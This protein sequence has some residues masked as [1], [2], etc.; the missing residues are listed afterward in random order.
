MFTGNGLFERTKTAQAKTVL[1][2]NR[3]N[4]L[5]PGGGYLSPQAVIFKASLE[6]QSHCLS[7]TGVGFS[8]RQ[9]KIEVKIHLPGQIYDAAIDHQDILAQGSHLPGD[10]SGHGDVAHHAAGLQVIGLDDGMG[11]AGQA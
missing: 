11:G 1:L 9:S 2:G 6:S 4:F 10:I 3:G 5:N 7:H 8:G